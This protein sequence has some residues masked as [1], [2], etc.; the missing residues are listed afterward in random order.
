MPSMTLEEKIRDCALAFDADLVG[1]GSRERFE[2]MRALTIAP[3]TQTVI[4]LA[5]R[6]LRGVYRGI[7]EGTTF[8]Q[9][10]TN[11]VEVLEEVIMPRTL[12]K[13]CGILEDAGYTAF[14]QRRHLCIMEAQQGHNFEVDYEEIYHSRHTELQMEWEE[15]A[16]RCGMGEI[17][18]HGA[19]L[20][21]AFGPMQRVCFILT[22]A[23]LE[24]TALSQPHL[25][26]RCRA[27]A[28][29]CPGHAID[30]GGVRDMWQCGAY[31]RGANR[32]RNPFMP[33]DAFAEFA[34]RESILRGDK[35][36]TDQQ[37]IQ[38]MEHC[39]YYPP[40]KQ[41]YASSICGKACEVACYEHLE[42]NNKLA[43]GFAQQFRRRSKWRLSTEE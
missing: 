5:F 6:V 23:P 13:V 38:V 26:D 1:F 41:G 11:G 27:C 18:F 9:Y 17:G 30:G 15:S 36:L 43:R 19:L 37:S 12:L 35:K 10:S 39:I 29:A 28:K 21:E 20:T 40:I 42:E 32:S 25:C 4:C 22:D 7:E 34:D 24:A 2:G 16:V 14:P 33:A 31:Y 3:G 8:Y